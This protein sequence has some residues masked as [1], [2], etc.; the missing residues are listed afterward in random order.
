[1]RS[2][3]SM[4]VTLAVLL[5]LALASVGAQAQTQTF[6]HP[7]T[8]LT[9]DVNTSPGVVGYNFYRVDAVGTPPV[10]DAAA[11][12]IKVNAAPLATPA[13]VD[14]AV[15]LGKTYCYASTAVTSLGDESPLS[16]YTAQSTVTFPPRPSANA[17]TRAIRH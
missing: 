8:E 12:P 16:P 9:N 15:T 3:R 5:L 7:S 13:A 17:N 11:T 1:M 10:C 2:S 14:T 6:P 4:L